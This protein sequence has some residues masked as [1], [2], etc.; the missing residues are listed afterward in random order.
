MGKFQPGKAANP[1]G[2]PKGTGKS[3]KLRELLEEHV[4]AAITALV[5][6]LQDSDGR[7]AVQAAK[8][9]LT[10]VYGVPVQAVPELPADQEPPQNPVYTELR[11]TDPTPSEFPPEDAH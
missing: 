5:A 7:V 1:T 2:R 9:I 3:P 8:E 11:R 10:R 6:A 4:P